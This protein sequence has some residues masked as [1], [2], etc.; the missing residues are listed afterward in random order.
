[1]VLGPPDLAERRRRG[2]SEFTFVYS[3]DF[4]AALAALIPDELERRYFKLDAL[5]FRL[6]RRHELQM[7]TADPDLTAT[8]Y[9]ITEEGLANAPECIVWFTISESTAGSRVCRFDAVEL[10]DARYDEEDDS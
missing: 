7:V 5:E 3:S 4:D 1:M 2:E 9:I 8:G 10:A 6:S